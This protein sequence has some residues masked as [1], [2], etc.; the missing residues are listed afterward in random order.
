MSTKK[1]QEVV[2]MGLPRTRFIGKKV[3]SKIYYYKTFLVYF[4]L[5]TKKA[6]SNFYQS[7]LDTQIIINVFLLFFTQYKNEWIEHKF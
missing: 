4:S 1:M 5:I 6:L 7:R 2:K 3:I